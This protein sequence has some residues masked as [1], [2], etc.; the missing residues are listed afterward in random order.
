MRPRPRPR[1]SAASQHHPLEHPSHRFEHAAAPVASREPSIV[2]AL[3]GIHILIQ[4]RGHRIANALRMAQRGGL[5]IVNEASPVRTA[6]RAQA[7]GLILT[8]NLPLTPLLAL[9][10]NLPQLFR[11]FSGVPA[12]DLW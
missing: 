1:P 4:Y 8:L 10:P 12:V 3:F 11:H 5:A 7:L 6:G 9:G 2:P